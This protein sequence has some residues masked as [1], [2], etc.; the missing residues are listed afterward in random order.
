MTP[1]LTG[2]VLSIPSP[3]TG[4]WEIFGF[5][6]RAYALCIIAG[7]VVGMMMS[8]RRW[9][10]RGGTADSLEA[11]VIVAIPFGIIGA[12]IYHVITDYQLYFGPGRDPLNAL[13]IW[14]GGLGIWG[15]VAL[16]AL[17]AY[18]VARRR[19]IRFAALLDALAPGLVVAQAIGRLGNW[20][21]SE[22]FGRPTTLPWGLEISPTN[23]PT[24]FEQYAT[25]HPTFLYELLWNLGVAAVLIWADRRFRLGHGK[26]FALYVV[27]YTAGRFWI[28]ALRIDQVNEIEGF[29]LN[30]YTSAI[31][32]VLALAWLLWLRKARPGREPVVEGDAAAPEAVTENTAAT[33]DADVADRR[34][35][36]PAVGPD[37]GRPSDVRPNGDDPG[38]GPHDRERVPDVS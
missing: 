31:L 33:T 21:N 2:V 12:R 19:K 9:R 26:V 1:G 13:K 29:R 24:G 16:G 22:L 7:I 27:L 3:S 5:P 34:D 36:Q 4:V 30:N 14:N 32:F 23:R 17:G 18:L 11:V 28:E 15:A 38:P 20:F 37:S 35:G 10:A 25:F 6:L 8:T